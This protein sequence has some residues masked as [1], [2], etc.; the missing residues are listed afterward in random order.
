MQFRE[1]AHLTAEARAILLRRSEQ[2]I[3]ALL[4]K[5]QA[6]IDRVRQEGDAA[7]IDFT[8]QFDTPNYTADNLKATPEDFQRA[9]EAVGSEVV[10]AIRHAHANIQRFHEE[11]LPQ[12]M[13]FTEVAPGIMAG[14]KITPVASAGLYVPRGK[15][16]FPSV[17]LML[18]IPARVAGVERIVVV[19]PP[20]DEGKA[21]AGSLV[22]ADVAG[23]NE[24]YAVGGMQ[25]VAGLAF[26]TET[27]P[28]VA[29]IVGPGSS[30]VTAAKR[31]LF[32][33]LDVGLP[34][35]PSESI[36]LCDESAS[37]Q[38]AAM[39][40]LVEAEHGPESAALLVTHDRSLAK[41]VEATLPG[42]IDTLPDWRRRFVE[43]VLGNYGGILLTPSLADSIAFVNE[44]A[45]EHLEIL[46][47]DPFGTLGKIH[48]AG[49]I[50]L[51]PYTPIPTSN[52]TL[53]LNAILPTGGF[54]RSFSSVSVWDFLKRSG[55][56]YLT[57]EGYNSLRKAT[58]TLADYEGFPAHAQSIR[59]RD[60]LLKLE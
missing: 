59:A 7:L 44:Y 29:K 36:V 13:W 10:A 53:G 32:G 35:G 47:T 50:L 11:Q 41:Q 33:T 25:A 28:K 40:L 39:D 27:L 4:P 55:I 21:D 43:T 48:N 6:V 9:Y 16:A 14:E 8:H 51:G 57:R 46:T 26:G 45:P 22:A 17:M 54:G 52:Y 56:G 49:E 30:Y 37:P 58:A 42:Y 34:A 20:N 60:A 5:A 12:P 23:I 1:L 31:L 38:L 24:V 2:D 15:G 3:A 19:T 18:S